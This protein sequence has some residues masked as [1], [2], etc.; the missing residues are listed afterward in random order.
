MTMPQGVLALAG[1]GVSSRTA[2][3]VAATFALGF[4]V[5]HGTVTLPARID[6]EPMDGS[7]VRV[8]GRLAAT[9]S[10][11]HDAHLVKYTL[12]CLHAAADDPSH[13]GLYLAAAQ[14]LTDWW[15]ANG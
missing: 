10:L 13:A 4:R 1:A 3:A 12:A 9:A 5:A 2:L 11:H 6:T 8:A 7:M 14:Y 15:R